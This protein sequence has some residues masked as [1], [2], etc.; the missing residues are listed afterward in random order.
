MSGPDGNSI[1]HAEIKI[2]DSPVM[3]SD[4]HPAWGVLD[5]SPGAG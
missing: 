1:V 4:E 3:L 5:H 2:G